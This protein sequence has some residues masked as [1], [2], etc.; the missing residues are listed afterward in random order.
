MWFQRYSTDKILK[1]KVAKIWSNQIYT[2]HEIVHLHLPNQYPRY[3]LP[4]LTISEIQPGPDIKGQCYFGK[5]KGQIKVTLRCCTHM[6]PT[7][8]PNKYHPSTAYGVWDK[9]T[10]T[11]VKDKVTTASQITN[12]DAHLHP[13]SPAQPVFPQSMNFLYLILTKIQPGPTK[14]PSLMSWMTAIPAKSSE[15]RGKKDTNNIFSG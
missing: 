3:Q 11:I 7:N 6:L 4:A 8:A 9:I 14:P 13:L 2:M 1:V 5:V 15:A 12:D 10:G